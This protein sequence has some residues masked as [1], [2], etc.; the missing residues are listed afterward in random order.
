[1]RDPVQQKARRF[2]QVLLPPRQLRII[3]RRPEKKA[4]VDAD[5]K[6][7]AVGIPAEWIPVLRKAGYQTVEALKAVE[8]PN[9]LHQELCGL[10][11]KQKLGLTPLSQD[12]VR[13]WL[14]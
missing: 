11:K 9:K 1:M 14:K 6:F 8:N 2:F 13:E 4:A 10:N 5:D 3:H 12:E 7:T